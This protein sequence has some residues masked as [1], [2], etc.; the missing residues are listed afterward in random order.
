MHMIRLSTTL[1]VAAALA[2]GPA[3]L[4]H[5][6]GSSRCRVTTPCARSVVLGK[7]APAAFVIAPAGGVIGIP[8]TVNV[9]CGNNCGGACPIPPTV[10][11]A[12]T[13]VNIVPG[14]PPCPVPPAVPIASATV[15]A[16]GGMPLPACSPGGSFTNFAV[17]VA[18]PAGTLG[19]FCLNA[20]TTITFS[21]GLVLTAF[22]DQL[23]CIVDEE[24]TMPGTPRLDLVLD[25]TGFVNGMPRC[26]PGDQINLDYIVT[27]NDPDESVTLTPT[28]TSTQVARLPGGGDESTGVFS[29][30]GATG[31]DFPIEFQAGPPTCLPLP[32]NPSTFVQ[33]P[34]SAP[35]IT[36]PPQTTQIVTVAVRS[37][38]R[39]S[40]GS[41]NETTLALDG[42]FSNGDPAFACAGTS[43]WVD[44]SIPFPG[45]QPPCV[46]C[47]FPEND[48]NTNGVYDAEDVFVQVTSPDENF[49]AGP[50]ECDAQEVWVEL[51]FPKPGTDG[52]LATLQGFGPLTPN[53]ANQLDLSGALPST[54][55]TLFVGLEAQF[56]PVK[57]GILVPFPFILQAPLPIGPGGQTVLPFQWPPG[58][59]PGTALFLQAWIQD[60]GATKGLAA[61]NGL[62]ANAQ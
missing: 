60:P 4:A 13:T 59:P 5:A 28:A 22:G 54:L 2:L 11:A 61:S 53:S 31:D 39:C 44:T 46:P 23:V 34:I 21:D 57:D 38:P 1:L 37:Y 48:C 36:I 50:D 55:A 10:V 33:P 6:C 51:F 47:G 45:G 25:T 18:I 58:I 40:G 19:L 16:P 14:P 62:Q 56:V 41:C 12:T 29:I 7:A 30:S 27:N 24:P 42:S 32:P 8:I 15:T 49:N 26:A 52:L 35:A 43:V 9:V 17:P 3:P 20:T